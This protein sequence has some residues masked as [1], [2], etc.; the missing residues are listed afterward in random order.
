MAELECLL[1]DG[2]DREV[3]AHILARH[4]A[5]ERSKERLERV[6]PHGGH[7]LA[8]LFLA[9]YK[10]NIVLRPVTEISPAVF[11]HRRLL[12]SVLTSRPLLELRKR[13]E[14]SEAECA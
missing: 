2:Y 7:L 4:V 14:L 3:F 1:S 13:T 12:E 11:V 6:L 9:L 5:V 8:D 10:L